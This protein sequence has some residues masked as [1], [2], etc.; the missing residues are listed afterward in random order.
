MS[1]LAKLMHGAQSAVS[2]AGEAGVH[3]CFGVMP[4]KALHA[5]S[6]D[7]L[8]GGW[9]SAAAIDDL[10]PLDGL[11]VTLRPWRLSDADDYHRMVSDPQLWRY[12]PEQVDTPIDTSAARDLLQLAMH[13]DL[14]TSRAIIWM[15]QPVGQVRLTRH[16]GE[17]P[18][19]SY[20]IG[21]SFRGNGLATS[22]V[23][24]FLDS[25]TADVTGI[26]AM[27]HRDNSASLRVMTAHGFHADGAARDPSFQR[28]VRRT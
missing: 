28:F 1:D 8:Q 25:L 12:L 9:V 13:H 3:R 16:H 18:E 23:G 6:F 4:V 21:A 26:C 15:D 27:V 7:S 10:T 5:K 22:A 24:A 14:S 11:R 2:F 17:M 20:W 19:L